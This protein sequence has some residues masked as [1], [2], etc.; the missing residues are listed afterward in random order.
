M[1]ILQSLLPGKNI[2]EKFIF[3]DN[4]RW[5]CL[6]VMMFTEDSRS[7]V[8]SLFFFPWYEVS[9][10]FFSSGKYLLDTLLTTQ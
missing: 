2:V 10:G 4:K 6:K 3:Q 1:K 8:C 5:N 7:A 9:K